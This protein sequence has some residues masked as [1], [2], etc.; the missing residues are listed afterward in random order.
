MGGLR[1][2]MPITAY[3]MLVGV[4]AIAGLSVPGVIAFSGYHS[5]DAI[6]ATALAFIQA[7]PAHFLLF[8]LPLLTAGITAFYMFRLWFFTFAGDPRDQH[9]YD[10]AHESPWIMTVPLLILAPFAAFCA[11]GG[12]GGA[13]GA[14]DNASAT[15]RDPR[16]SA[17]RAGD[18]ACNRADGGSG[19]DA[20]AHGAQDR[21]WPRWHVCRV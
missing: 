7:N 1:K 13:G 21:C 16:Q 4:I 6:V 9:V 8:L 12:E 19:A 11:A 5:K 3:T 10:H 20:S 14:G 18:C 17:E 15:G 2:K